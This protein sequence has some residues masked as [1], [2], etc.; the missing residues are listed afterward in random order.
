MNDELYEKALSLPPNERV[1]FAELILASLEHEDEEIR[2]VW[3]KEI[4]ERI[5]AV[6]EGR[7]K[8]LDFDDLYNAG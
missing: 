6:K 4:Q 8:L 7:A 3:I 1:K 5:T 2:S